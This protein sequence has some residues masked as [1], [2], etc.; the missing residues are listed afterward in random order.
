MRTTLG[1]GLLLLVSSAA[2][3]QSPGQAE[4][5]DLFIGQL[6][7]PRWRIREKAS[8]ALIR[9]GRPAIPA[10]R[11]ALQ[12]KDLE[13]AARA[14]SILEAIQEADHEAVGKGRL[15][16]AEAFEKADYPA[17]LKHAQTVVDASARPAPID[18]LSLGH[19]AQLNGQWKLAVKAYKAVAADRAP[20]GADAPPANDG[21]RAGP[22]V[23]NQISPVRRG[24]LLWWTARMEAAMLNDPA[25]AAATMADAAEL[26]DRS[27][28]ERGYASQVLRERMAMLDRAGK[29][30]EVLETWAAL[31]K[32]IEQTG[33]NHLNRPDPQV[34]ARAYRAAAPAD[35]GSLPLLIL[36]ADGKAEVK[37]EKGQVGC[38]YR[39]DKGG[40]TIHWWFAI[41]APKGK[42]F[43]SVKNVADVEQLNPR[44]GGQ[45]DCFIIPR[46][47]G[48]SHPIT[49]IGWKGDK[50]GRADCT[51]S[52]QVPEGITTLHIHP[53]HWQTYFAVHSFTV[54]A[55]FRAE[56][57]KPRPLQ[58]GAW[59]QTELIPAGGKLTAGQK[60]LANQRAYSGF[61]PGAYPVTYAVEGRDPVHLDLT[62]RGGHRYGLFIN[63]DSPFAWRQMPMTDLGQHPPQAGSV[64]R[65]PKGGWLAT[66]TTLDMQVALAISADGRTWEA[67]DSPSPKVFR[68]M[69]P[70][71]H[72]DSDG[73][74]W[75]AFV[76]KRLELQDS[77]YGN[78]R[79]WITRSTDGLRWENPRRVEA[80]Q[81]TGWPPSVPQLIEA[82]DGKRWV[83]WGQQGAA[84]KGF[85]DIRELTLFSSA[86]EGERGS[87]Y[88]CSTAIDGK[89]GFHMLGI[90]GAVGITHHT[91]DDGL[92]WSA[93]RLILAQ[94]NEKNKYPHA[95]RWV[96]VDNGIFLYDTTSGAWLDR[97]PPQGRTLAIEGGLQ[98][99]NHVVGPG[100]GQA[101][102]DGDRVLLMVGKDTAWLLSAKLSDLAA[103]LKP[104]AAPGR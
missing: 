31:H 2:L 28:N 32:A 35:A 40:D 95:P 65:L 24:H 57:A 60:E 56:T 96:D 49:R 45:L 29:P 101:T 82:P 68:S 8:Q 91:S 18:W 72:V 10:L 55:T 13:T 15:A 19:A 7:S 21:R 59:I 50:P 20:V 88:R 53:S 23:G 73:T 83:F 98:V 5:I 75:L 3:A 103:A 47:G 1:I 69:A 81:L 97:L 52:G 79:L 37:L 38:S 58:E 78:D 66:W 25:A 43:A 62:V 48:R 70:A 12:S 61:E 11:E 76:S 102:R 34:L 77:A 27:G 74:I 30:A 41:P 33:E 89:G 71:L 6:S 44:G 16:V 104:P 99:A 80:A 94:D 36:D 22:A 67:V 17:M 90:K 42:E 39:M 84:A 93:G 63:L 26:F 87:I 51:A 85:G 46:D 54:E 86:G 64:V 9:I 4:K 92:N 14:A 100:W